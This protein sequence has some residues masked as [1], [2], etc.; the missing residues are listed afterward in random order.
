MPPI[1]FYYSI[2]IIRY[3]D[4]SY[5]RLQRSPLA[6][7]TTKLLEFLFSYAIVASI[8]QRPVRKDDSRSII[9]LIQAKAIRSDA[10]EAS[11]YQ[12]LYMH[13]YNKVFQQSLATT[14]TTTVRSALVPISMT[15]V[16]VDLPLPVVELVESSGCIYRY[17]AQL[18]NVTYTYR[19]GILSSSISSVKVLLVK[20]YCRI[21]TLS[22]L[23]LLLALRSGRR[24]YQRRG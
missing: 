23:L 4:P 12:V 3:Y 24:R 20:V 22:F 8:G 17:I 19:G 6:L 13:R 18:Y 21:Q 15:L 16:A 2:A 1:L 9:E 5:A 11:A 10:R 14:S 7:R